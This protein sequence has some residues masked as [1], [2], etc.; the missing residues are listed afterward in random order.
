MNINTIKTSS[1]KKPKNYETMLFF[2]LFENTFFCFENFTFRASP[3]IRD[4]FPRGAGGYSMFRV[5]LKRI[6]DIMTFKAYP[7]DRSFLSQS[8]QLLLT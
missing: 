5:S 3:R 4:F 6:I 8:G 2:N 1:F 7:S